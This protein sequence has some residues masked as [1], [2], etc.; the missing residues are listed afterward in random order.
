M[1]TGIVQGL[2]GDGGTS[3]LSILGS[4]L[5]LVAWA[6][7][8]AFVVDLVADVRDGERDFGVGRLFSSASDA[9]LPLIGNGILFA[10]AVTVGLVLLVVPGLFLLT[11]WAVAP[12][13]VVAERRG[14]I[15][16]FGR[17][18]FSSFAVTPGLCSE[19]S[20]SPS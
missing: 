18:Y 8:A 12:A 17:S 13:A 11:V 9:V 7:F 10:I 16:A 4:L 15:E 2:C 5:D 6:F 14:A 3:C 20:S 19:R 1:V